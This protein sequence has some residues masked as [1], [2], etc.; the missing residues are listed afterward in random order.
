M[1]LRID[2]K[3]EIIYDL[4][5]H[6]IFVGKLTVKNYPDGVVVYH[7]YSTGRIIRW[8]LWLDEQFRSY[9]GWVDQDIC[10]VSVSQLKRR[11]EE[12]M[13][14]RKALTTPHADL[15]GKSFY[16]HRKH[17]GGTKDEARVRKQCRD[18]CRALSS[19]MG[20]PSLVRSKRYRQL[21]IKFAPSKGNPRLTRRL[22][23]GD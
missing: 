19:T 20:V 17:R 12:G 8:G 13:S 6:Q 4:M 22:V 15:R 18:A 14:V 1:A 5:E 7:E 3:P 16:Q 11:I 9:Q 23:K 2:E 21:T 10:V